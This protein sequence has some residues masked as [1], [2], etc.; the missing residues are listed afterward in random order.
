[1]NIIK[2]TI[3]T[4]LITCSAYAPLLSME[5]LCSA[6]ITHEKNLHL[7]QFNAKIHGERARNIHQEAFDGLEYVLLGKKDNRK[8]QVLIDQDTVV[9]VII[10]QDCNINQSTVRYVN[11][12]CVDSTHRNKNYGS[13]LMHKFEQE[14]HNQGITEIQ[15]SPTNRSMP[16]YKRLGFSCTKDYKMTKKACL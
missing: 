15:L 8:A 12:L 5:S 16:F 6:N 4:G 7:M 2:K 14:T 11:Y 3:L 13:C 1:M 9:G 10:Y